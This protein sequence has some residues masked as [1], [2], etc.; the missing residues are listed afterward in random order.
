MPPFLKRSFETNPTIGLR[1]LRY[2][3]DEQTLF[4]AQLRA[5]LEISRRANIQILFPMVI[6]SHDFGLARQIVHQ[7][8]EEMGLDA[9]PSL[10]AMI[11]TPAAVFT[12]EEILEQADF[13]SLGTND[14]T[15]LVLAADRASASSR[16]APLY[17]DPREKSSA[18]IALSSII[19]A[20]RYLFSSPRSPRGGT[21][22]AEP[23]SSRPF[24]TR[25]QNLVSCR[26]A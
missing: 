25:K 13:I 17:P 19:I 3:L 22:R 7:M 16:P 6:G 11:E 2:S 18:A 14:L 12:V 1:G 20:S 5:I 8:S 26:P 10:G 15:Q 4:R 21:S 9:V 23:T 24:E